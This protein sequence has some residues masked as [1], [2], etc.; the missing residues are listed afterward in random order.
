MAGKTHRYQLRA[1][2]KMVRRVEK[3][4]EQRISKR[5]N[6]ALYVNVDT[7]ESLVPEKADI[8][9]ALEQNL[10]DLHQE[11]RDLVKRVGGQSAVIREHS[12]QLINLSEKQRETTRYLARIASLDAE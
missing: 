3:R 8:L 2:R 5:V 9:S 10:S 4:D 11:H 12:R 6:G 1:V 7:I